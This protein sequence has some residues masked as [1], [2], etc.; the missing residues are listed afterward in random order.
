MGPAVADSVPNVV[1]DDMVLSPSW[2]DSLA[3]VNVDLGLAGDNHS[4]PSQ[5]MLSMDGDSALWPT[6]QS[7][8]FEATVMLPGM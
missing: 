7:G 8:D 5:T 3:Q 1:V 4:H 6:S 2:L